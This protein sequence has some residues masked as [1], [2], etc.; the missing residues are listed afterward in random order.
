MGAQRTDRQSVCTSA[1]RVGTAR[2]RGDGRCCSPRNA[3]PTPGS[4]AALR[5]SRSFENPVTRHRDDWTCDRRELFDSAGRRVIPHEFGRRTGTRIDPCAVL[6]PAFSIEPAQSRECT[7]VLGHGSSHDAARALVPTALLGAE[8]REHGVRAH[9]DALLRHGDGRYAGPAVRCAGESLV[10][11]SGARV[12][13]VGARRLLSGRRRVR[14]PRSIAGL[15]GAGDRRAAVVAQTALVVR[16]PTV[17][18]RGRAALVAST[19][20]RRRAHA[21]QR[22]LAVAAVRDGAL[23]GRHRRRNGARRDRHVPRRRT[24]FPTAPKTPI[25]YRAPANSAHRCTNTARARSI[26]ASGSVHTVCR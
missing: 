24:R 5:S 16:V 7:F 15:D 9:W 22:R 8:S 2:N 1:E 6:A 25:S 19:V 14:L 13:V 12:S 11:V 3:T 26:A 20:R 21:I 18:R 4:A 10:A 17:R 23:R